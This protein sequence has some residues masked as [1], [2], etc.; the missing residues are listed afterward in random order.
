MYIQIILGSIRFILNRGFH[1]KKLLNGTVWICPNIGC[2]LVVA[3]RNLKK[4][5]GKAFHKQG[6]INPLL[7]L[8]M[9]PL[10]VFF[11]VVGK[12]D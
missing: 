10:H 5:H 4:S 1:Q 8:L 12:L 2:K 3:T 7:F 9:N 6:N 11:H